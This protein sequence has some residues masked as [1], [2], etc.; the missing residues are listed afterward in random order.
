MQNL[1]IPSAFFDL[2]GEKWRGTNVVWY[3]I[4]KDK[5]GTTLEFQTDNMEG[6]FFEYV[7]NDKELI[8]FLDCVGR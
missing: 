4:H 5:L 8:E 1:D 3:Q 7:V 2:G 6:L